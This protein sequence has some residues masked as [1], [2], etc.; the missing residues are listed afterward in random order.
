MVSPLLGPLPARSSWGEDGEL[1]AATGHSRRG[2]VPARSPGEVGPGRTKRVETLADQPP[3]ELSPKALCRRE[4]S[5]GS[6]IGCTVNS[7]ASL[8]NQSGQRASPKRNLPAMNG[9]RPMRLYN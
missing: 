5:H 2:G 6:G 1:D 8:R 9:N 7:S 3:N 4:S